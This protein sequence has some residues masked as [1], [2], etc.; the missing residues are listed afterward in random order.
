VVRRSFSY[1]VDWSFGK[2]TSLR[3]AILL[4]SRHTV[5]IDRPHLITNSLLEFPDS[6]GRLAQTGGNMK[7]AFVVSALVM[8]I[9]VLIAVVSFS[10][11][12]AE[13]SASDG[14]SLVRV[15]ESNYEVNSE[16]T[17][18]V[19][20]QQVV[21]LWSIRELDTIQAQ[22]NATIIDGQIGI[23]EGQAKSQAWAQATSLLLVLLIGLIGMWGVV[24][25]R[26][27]LKQT[28]SSQG[29]SPAE[30]AAPPPERTQ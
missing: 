15:A 27:F 9:A 2:R 25:G 19:Y 28:S 20:Q 29:D 12:P 5:G 10:A 13:Y 4:A 1:E 23:L 11:Q 17:E 14:R 30:A 21:A 22:Q 18:N 16:N 8:V 24:F 6:G 3:I 26:H 7:F